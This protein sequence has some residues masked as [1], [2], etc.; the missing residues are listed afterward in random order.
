MGEIYKRTTLW[1][2]GKR[3]IESFQGVLGGAK[4][5]SS[6]HSRVQLGGFDALEL[7]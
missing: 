3:G 6:I 4:W 1:F 2:V 7:Q 5:I